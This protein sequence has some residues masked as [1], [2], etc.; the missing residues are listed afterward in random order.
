MKIAINGF[1]RIGR[2]VFKIAFERPG[3]DIAAI[4]DVADPAIMAHVLKHDSS[5]GVYKRDVQVKNN[6]ILVDKTEI[7][8]FSQSNPAGLP[9][10]GLDVEVVI[11]ATGMFR[12]AQGETGGYMDHVTKA[13]AGKVILTELAEDEI[14]TFIPG[15]SDTA[16]SD[17]T[18]ALSMACST[19]NCLAVML[20]VLNQEY[21]IRQVFFTDIHALTTEKLILDSAHKNLSMAR[22]AM[23]NIAPGESAAAASIGKII[24]EL[25]DRIDGM[26]ISVPVPVGSAVDLVVNLEKSADQEAVN[27]LFHKAANDEMRGVLEYSSAPLVSSDIKGNSHSCIFDSSYTL[28]ISPGFVKILGWFDNEFGYATRLVDLVQKL[29]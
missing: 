14:E 23:L 21:G 16:I 24:P 17:E 2:N 25:I 5:Y 6:T 18:T 10:G 29:E 27:A 8:V 1:G 20:K 11:E 12:R 7:P 28:A 9:W 13:G 22:S 26:S 15:V 3:I 19:G 4:N